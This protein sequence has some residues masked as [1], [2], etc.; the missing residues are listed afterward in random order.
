MYDNCQEIENFSTCA[1]ISVS[2]NKQCVQLIGFYCN[3]CRFVAQSVIHAVLSRNL[4]CH[5][6]GAFLWRKIEP[7]STFVEKK[8]QIWGLS[9]GTWLLLPRIL[10]YP[11]V[12]PKIS[13]CQG[14]ICPLVMFE[15]WLRCFLWWHLVWCLRDVFCFCRWRHIFTCTILAAGIVVNKVA[16][17]DGL[18]QEWLHGNRLGQRSHYFLLRTNSSVALREQRRSANYVRAAW[19]YLEICDG[20]QRKQMEKQSSHEFYDSWLYFAMVVYHPGFGLFLLA[21]VSLISA[22]KHLISLQ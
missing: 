1:E 14:L 10:Y 12:H 16:L 11:P 5:N 7:K 20:W 15:K 3:L 17:R 4:F 22:W 8:W 18:H 9:Q 21:I 6:L 19:L 13:E 2:K